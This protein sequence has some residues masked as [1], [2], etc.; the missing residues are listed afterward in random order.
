MSHSAV[1]WPP[2]AGLISAAVSRNRGPL[3][4]VCPPPGHHSRNPAFPSPCYP[5]IP[6]AVRALT[7][8]PTSVD[9]HHPPHQL[10]NMLPKRRG[11]S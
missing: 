7:P 4:P 5:C 2:Q 8:L 11:L 6:P 3:P 10:T 9:H 1:M